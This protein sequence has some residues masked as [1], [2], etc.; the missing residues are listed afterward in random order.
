MDMGRFVDL[1]L[2]GPLFKVVVELQSLVRA[3][4]AR[5][6]TESRCFD[7]RREQSGSQDNRENVEG[8]SS[9]VDSC[10]TELVVEDSGRDTRMRAYRR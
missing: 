5:V 3:V 4:Y 6:R 9:V 1:G 10:C 8:E 7:G 2:S